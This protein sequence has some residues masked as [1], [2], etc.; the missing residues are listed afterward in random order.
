MRVKYLLWLVGLGLT[1]VSSHAFTLTPM[2]TTL[3]SKGNG[4]A[5][6]FRVENESS[7]RVAFQITLLTRDMDED[8]KETN[9]P[10]TDLFTV[11]PPQGII[12]PGQSQ[13]VRLVWK[14]QANFTNE[15]AYRLLAEELPVNFTPETNKA[16]IKVLLRYMA[17]VYV[18]PKNAKPKLQVASFTQTETNAFVMTVTNAG[19]AHQPLIDPVL[20]LTDARGQTQKIP[21]GQV[22]SI[23]GQNI[24]AKHTRRFVLT[25][26]P[27]FKQSNYQ[28]QLTADE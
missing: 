9:Q 14:G 8:G 13:T 5:R 18:R 26:P 7:N 23:A 11:F 3:D 25:L 6:S 2:S 28:A 21:S 4:S 16:Q 10:A 12:A 27:D 20:T 19:N 24:L 15:L 17:A 22:L 1:M